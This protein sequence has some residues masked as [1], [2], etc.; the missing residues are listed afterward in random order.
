[1]GSHKLLI[2]ED[3]RM[4]GEALQSILTR[5]PEIAETRVVPRYEEILAVA[6]RFLPNLI[7]LDIS[8]NQQ[9]TIPL[10]RE[11]RELPS[12][13]HILVLTMHN[14]P[15]I[16]QAALGSG[17][18]G[19]LLKDSGSSALVEAVRE[20][21]CGRRF[22]EPTIVEALETRPVEVGQQGS[23]LFDRYDGLTR[24]EQEVLKLLAEGHKTGA[25]AESLGISRKTADTH[26]YN[27]MRKLEAETTAQL[28]KIALRL[29]VVSPEE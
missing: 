10:I 6:S 14:D 24:R 2:V 18:L 12:R 15:V 17:A 16:C 27:V 4:F 26:R 13:P 5:L 21:M 9:S 29:G 7:T 1:M 23:L 25:V 19:Y 20:V 11:L 28:I 22:L 3:H 8:V